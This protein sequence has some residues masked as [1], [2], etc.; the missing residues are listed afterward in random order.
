MPGAY[1]RARARQWVE[2]GDGARPLRGWVQAT[3]QHRPCRGPFAP[4]ARGVE[5]SARAEGGAAEKK[6]ANDPEGVAASSGQAQASGWL[7]G[8]PQRPGFGGGRS[9]ARWASEA[10]HATPVC[11]SA[12]SRWLDRWS[13]V[14]RSAWRKAT[15]NGQRLRW[16]SAARKPGWRA[17]QAHRAK[18]GRAAIPP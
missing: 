9:P 11:G 17:P 10:A 3:A 14:S 7:L 5:G 4:R 15:R 18:Q 8:T 13:D 16:S 2:H 6:P 1:W 12:S